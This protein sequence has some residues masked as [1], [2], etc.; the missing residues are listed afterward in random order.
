M[1]PTQ[2]AI[3]LLVS[4]VGGAAVLYVTIDI[5]AWRYVAKDLGGKGKAKRSLSIPLGMCERVTYTVSIL[6]G[7]PTWIGVWLAIKVAAQWNRWQGEERATYN[8][9]LIGNLLSV[10]CSLVGAWIALGSIPQL[11]DQ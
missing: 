5:V 11:G 4:A 1:D 3:G 7:A 2:V 10:L 8:V 9:F 6:L